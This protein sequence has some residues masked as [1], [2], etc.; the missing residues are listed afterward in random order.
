MLKKLRLVEI[1]KV[2]E[3]FIYNLQIYKYRWSKGE[4]IQ[5]PVMN[6]LFIYYIILD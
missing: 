5:I 4:W 2:G 6:L 1:G 3:M